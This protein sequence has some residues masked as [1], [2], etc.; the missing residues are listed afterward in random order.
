MN[1]KLLI[2]NLEKKQNVILFF[3]STHC[4]ACQ[5]AK[6]IVEKI[7]KSNN[8]D[9]ITYISPIQNASILCTIIDEA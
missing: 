6:P 7:V 3:S 2:E 9:Y 8:F 4:G 1:K 5:T